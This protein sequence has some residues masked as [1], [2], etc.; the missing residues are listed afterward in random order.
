MQK[1]QKLETRVRV[2]VLAQNPG[3]GLGFGF[4][5]KGHFSAIQSLKFI[6]KGYYMQVE[7]IVASTLLKT[8]PFSFHFIYQFL[9]SEK[10]TTGICGGLIIDAPIN[11]IRTVQC[12]F[13]IFLNLGSFIT[14]FYQL[15]LANCASY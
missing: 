9:L 12:Q 4:A 10:I 15:L 1:T 6:Y 5:Y 14:F 3:L 8:A 2:W 7:F 13:T 11:G